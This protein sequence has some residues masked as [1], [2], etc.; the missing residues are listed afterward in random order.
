MSSMDRKQQSTAS[1]VRRSKLSGP[2]SPH[3]C[4]SLTLSGSMTLCS[5]M[6]STSSRTAVFLIITPVIKGKRQPA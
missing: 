3:S 2:F 5:P 1:A 6:S 4:P